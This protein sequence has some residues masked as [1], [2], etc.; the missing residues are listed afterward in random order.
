[1]Y[2]ANSWKGGSR[3]KYSPPTPPLMGGECPKYSPPIEGE[4]CNFPYQ[5]YSPPTPPQGQ[6]SPPFTPPP[7]EGECS[8]FAN[9]RNS[10]ATSWVRA[11]RAG[12]NYY[13]GRRVTIDTA[14]AG[15]TTQNPN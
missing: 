7:I 14:P 13:A 5:K 3:P 11:P 2:R 9:L 10:Y 15:L 6:K 1:M 12:H 4:S 8:I